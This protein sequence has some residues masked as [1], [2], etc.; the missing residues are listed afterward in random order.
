MTTSGADYLAAQEK[1]QRFSRKVARWY[2]EGLWDLMLTPTMRIPPT[3]LGAFKPSAQAPSRWIG[4]LYSFV[5]FTRT[6]NLT[7]QPAMSVPLYWSDDSVPIGVQ[8]A[9][10]FGDEETLFSLAGQLERSRPWI[11]RTPPLHCSNHP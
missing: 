3:Q 5:A 7:G 10:R 8:F 4:L 9:G 11:D 1:I 6:Q 2:S